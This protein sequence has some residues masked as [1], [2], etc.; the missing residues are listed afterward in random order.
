M[1]PKMPKLVR[2]T[3][4]KCKHD[5]CKNHV[6]DYSYDKCEDCYIPKNRPILTRQNAVIPKYFPVPLKVKSRV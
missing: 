2:Q 6:S 1:L 4:E 3:H 5:G